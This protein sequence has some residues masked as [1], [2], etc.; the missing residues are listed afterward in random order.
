MQVIKAQFDPFRSS[1]ACSEGIEKVTL[2]SKVSPTVVA[3]DSVH[4][5]IKDLKLS[6]SS[7]FVKKAESDAIPSTYKQALPKSPVYHV[8]P[9]KLQ[10]D[11]DDFL[12]QIYQGTF[13]IP[14][15]GKIY[16]SSP[17]MDPVAWSLEKSTFLPRT[18]AQLACQDFK[19]EPTDSNTGVLS[20]Q[21]SYASA[22]ILQQIY[23][24]SI[25]G[26]HVSL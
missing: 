7:S 8:V 10:A 3:H 19:K 24:G 20:P 23:F 21:H 2:P 17:G 25:V 16:C 12:L 11:L 14:C 15:G 1:A 5:A 4:E 26:A 13:G 6:T 18:L 9:V 22:H